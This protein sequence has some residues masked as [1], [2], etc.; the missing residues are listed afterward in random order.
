VVCLDLF[1]LF[2]SYLFAEAHAWKLCIIVIGFIHSLHGRGHLRFYSE[3][4]IEPSS[5]TAA[6]YARA[7]YAGL[8]A[9]DGFNQLNYV[10]AEMQYPE[11]DV[12]RAIHVSMGLVAVRRASL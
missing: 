11:R 7:L 6:S 8:W 1:C 3:P 10:A 4:T 5:P 12:P 9:F 2:F